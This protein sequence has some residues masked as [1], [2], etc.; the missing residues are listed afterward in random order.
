MTE[1]T[2][3][4]FF[5]PSQKEISRFEKVGIEL[6]DIY[7]Q[8]SDKKEFDNLIKQVEKVIRDMP[9]Y[10]KWSQIRASEHDYCQIC[11]IPFEETGLKK[12]VHHTPVTLYEIVVKELKQMTEAE[13]QFV[14]T[15]ELIDRVIEKHL[16][17]EVMSIVVCPCCH[18]RCHYE[19]KEFGN[20]ISLERRLQELEQEKDE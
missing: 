10:K 20:E 13:Q 15:T 16:S 17:G 4:Q 11:G 2:L 5:L 19:K 12:H 14:K 18:K 9:E 1:E 7:Y 6:N 8:R 3:K